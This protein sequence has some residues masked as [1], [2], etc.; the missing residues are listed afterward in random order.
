MQYKVLDKFLCFCFIAFKIN[1]I[2]SLLNKNLT[3]G[4]THSVPLTFEMMATPLHSLHYGILTI[5]SRSPIA[6]VTGDTNQ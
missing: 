1:S 3:L 4:I 6:F 5:Q 2:L